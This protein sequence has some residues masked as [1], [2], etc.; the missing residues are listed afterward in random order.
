[1][2]IDVNNRKEHGLAKGAPAEATMMNVPDSKRKAVHEAKERHQKEMAAAVKAAED[3]ARKAAEEAEAM[4]KQ[5]EQDMLNHFQTSMDEL[6]EDK[7]FS[8]QWKDSEAVK[9]ATKT[10]IEKVKR[11]KKVPQCG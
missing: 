7:E 10:V 1:M 3:A 5:L 9:R 4:R 8:D 11:A 2:L 6:M